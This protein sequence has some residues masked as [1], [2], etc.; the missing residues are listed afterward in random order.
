MYTF[1]TSLNKE[2]WNSTSKT[3]LLS[4][5]KN[6]TDIADIVIYSEDAISLDLFSNRVTYKNLYELCPE[7]VDFKNKYADNPHYNGRIGTKHESSSKAFKWKA[8]KFAHKTF[9]IFAEAKQQVDSTVVWLDADVLMHKPVTL[10][11]LQNLF[12]EE[13]SISY[14]GR[15]EAYDECG[16]MSYNLKHKFTREFLEKFENE[17]LNGLE[18]LRETH[19]SWVFYQLRLGYKDQTPF[20]NLNPN[21]VDNKSP[22][23]NSG[24]KDVMVHTKGTNKER[25]QH[26]FLK[27]FLL[28]EARKERRNV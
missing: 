8:I 18:H 3:N 22:F 13:K 20:H 21:P 14:L 19:D 5:D 23:N 24:I 26:K 16:L 9:A 1:V 10:E 28:E 7:L 25:L 27:R 6:L 12:P 17:Y 2:Y 11:Y 15:P 4:W